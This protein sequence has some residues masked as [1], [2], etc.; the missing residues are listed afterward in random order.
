[1][2]QGAGGVEVVCSACVLVEDAVEAAACGAE[3]C[4]VEGSVGAAV[5]LA[6][7]W[8]SAFDHG[9]PP[10]GWGGWVPARQRGWG[11]LRGALLGFRRAFAS[12]TLIP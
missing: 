7:A 5:C 6:F 11:V 2:G 12:V 3:V 9:R 1:M 4:L 8:L 10:S